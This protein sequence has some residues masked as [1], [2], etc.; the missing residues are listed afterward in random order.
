MTKYN[1]Q[2]K[3]IA[4][5]ELIFA[6][7]IMGIVML[8]APLMLTTATK[9]SLVAFQQES[10]AIAAAHAN[11]LMT[12]AWDEKN[13]K[14][15]SGGALQSRILTVNDGD[16]ELVARIPGIRRIMDT[17]LSSL[18]STFGNADGNGTIAGLF[19][20]LRND[21]IDDFHGAS[22]SLSIANATS[23]SA[24]SYQDDYMDINITLQTDVSYLDDDINYNSCGTT[25]NGC[26]FNRPFNGG[27]Q[28]ASSNIKRI[29]ITLTS[30]NV[31]GKNILLKSFMCNIGAANPIKEDGF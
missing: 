3:A 27:D 11:T 31:S 24:K 13:T 8:S 29:E 19:T 6:I 17:N 26:A 10:I 4:M 16:P 12:Y 14:S 30:S 1:T 15:Y 9:S 7:V 21:D 22:P 28:V 20:E 5:I 2:R 18:S 23:T 25:G